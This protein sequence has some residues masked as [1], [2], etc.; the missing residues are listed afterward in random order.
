MKKTHE[1]G[2]RQ[3]NEHVVVGV[4]RI[5]ECAD[6]FNRPLEEASTHPREEAD[7]DQDKDS[8][9]RC[10]LHHLDVSMQKDPEAPNHYYHEHGPQKRSQSVK[11][12]DL[13]HDDFSLS[14]PI[15]RFPFRYRVP[16]DCENVVHDGHANNPTLDSTV[17]LLFFRVLHESRFKPRERHQDQQ[18]AY[19]SD[20]WH[21]DG[22]F[23]QI[24]VGYISLLGFAVPV[25]VST[26][27]Y[28]LIFN[29]PARSL[30]NGQSDV[31]HDCDQ[32]DQR[33][34]VVCIPSLVDFLLFFRVFRCSQPVESVNADVDRFEH[35]LLA[36]VC[37]EFVPIDL[38]VVQRVGTF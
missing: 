37:F 18:T 2:R 23:G 21:S 10:S 31:D 35:V 24:T 19:V 32:P 26:R 3:E 17:F 30:E 25:A 29:A 36:H 14:P 8:H 22:K 34:P 33:P 11:T 4:A 38:F 9:R 5:R 20:W 6:S 27:G 13:F 12:Q 1:V 28:V 15:V 7:V 16:E